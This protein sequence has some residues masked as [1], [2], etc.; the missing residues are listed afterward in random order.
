MTGEIIVEDVIYENVND[1]GTSPPRNDPMFRRLT[2]E[3]SLGLVQSEAL[4]VREDS[5]P[6]G[7]REPDRR[8]NISS[9]SKRGSQRRTNSRMPVVEGKH[10]HVCSSLYTL[11]EEIFLTCYYVEYL[12]KSGFYM[13][14][15]SETKKLL[16]PMV[17][18]STFFFNLSIRIIPFFFCSILLQKLERK[19][20]I[21]QKVWT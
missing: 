9:K 15:I 10:I 4:L 12:L 19:Q 14:Y 8:K 18:L 17:C 16:H 3:R 20:Y 1:H 7:L 2:F 5:T 6:K 13:I 21:Y 11:K